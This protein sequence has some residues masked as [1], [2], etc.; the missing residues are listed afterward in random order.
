MTPHK[1]LS[2]SVSTP[3][4]TVQSQAQDAE[5]VM[6]QA[7]KTSN[8]VVMGTIISAFVPPST[9]STQVIKSLPEAQTRWKELILYL[10]SEMGRAQKS[11]HSLS[12]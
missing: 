3:P 11:S 12:N 9:T 10:T 5:D 6:A 4:A 8:V 2:S 7:Q 1:P